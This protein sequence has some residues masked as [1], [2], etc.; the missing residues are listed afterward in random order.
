M[1]CKCICST[2][3]AD[4]EEENVGHEQADLNQMEE[5]VI[6]YEHAQQVYKFIDNDNLL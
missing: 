4:D 3:F 2:R 1:L 5:V 6:L